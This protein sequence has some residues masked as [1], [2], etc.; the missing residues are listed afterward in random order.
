VAVLRALADQAPAPLK[1]MLEGWLNRDAEAAPGWGG[2]FRRDD[3]PGLAIYGHVL[4]Q[5]EIRRAE[6]AAGASA[7]EAEA[8][9]AGI[10][11][12]F[13]RGYRYGWCYSAEAPEGEL[14]SVHVSRCVPVA[15]FVR[16]D[17]SCLSGVTAAS[18]R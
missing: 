16:T 8:A 12:A 10:A 14:G 5:D 9:L 6:Q 4:N 11:Q 18:W 3:V 17:R 7:E 13:K 1:E 2:Y 15:S